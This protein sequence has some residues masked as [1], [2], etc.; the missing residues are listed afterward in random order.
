MTAFRIK[1]TSIAPGEEKMIKIQV[2][3]L[4]SGTPISIRIYVYRSVE[5][6]PTALVLGGVHGDEINGVE[7][8][9]RVIEEGLF[10]KL[11]RG[12]VIA[13]PLLNV[14]GFINFSRDVLDGKDVNRSFPGTSRG[15]LASRVAHTISKLILPLIHFGMDFHTGGA[16]RFNY[17]QVRYSLGDARAAELAQQF[18]AP[19]L[20]EKPFVVKSLR[21]TA[22]NQKKPILVFEGGE[23]LRLDG[24]CIEQGIAGMKRV[25]H[26]NQMLNHSDPP[27]TP[28][29]Q[30]K[31]TSWIRAPRS[32]MFTWTQSSGQHVEKG[33][34]LGF[35]HTPYGEPSTLIRA[36]KS[37]YIIGHN[38][39]PV[40]SAGDA[41]FHIGT[42]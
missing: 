14:Y 25:L 40:I 8:V 39:V 32:G 29:L 21:R 3:R 6:G 12:S 42:V 36:P 27:H 1:E 41:L 13:I 28:S 2:A 31:K 23:S 34:P 33:E 19:Y 38:N 20:I 37:G 7:I 17:P 15:S 11:V 16:M 10:S 24:F 18:A 30:I 4:P 9:R 35:F 22:F 26:H 5:P